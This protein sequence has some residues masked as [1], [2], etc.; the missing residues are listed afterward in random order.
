MSL[1]KKLTD[2]Y[3]LVIKSKSI[4]NN[5]KGIL[6]LLKLYDRIKDL[7]TQIKTRDHERSSLHQN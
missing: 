6:R 4:K 7:E 1:N 3:Q 5:Q 2:I